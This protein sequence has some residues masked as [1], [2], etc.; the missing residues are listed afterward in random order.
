MR[1]SGA[2]RSGGTPEAQA[3][4]EGTQ[5][6]RKAL[7]DTVANL[8]GVQVDHYAEVGLLGF[9]LLTKAVGGVD[10]CLKDAVNEPFSGARFRRP[11]VRPSTGRRHWASCVSVTICRAAI[12][13][14]S[15][16]SRPTWRR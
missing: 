7:I 16:G 14:G 3:E 4:K 9:V 15:P 2:A 12:S 6:G 5:A 11:A 10:V 8:T 13:T 1:V